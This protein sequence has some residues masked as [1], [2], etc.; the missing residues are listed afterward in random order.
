[1]NNANP[2]DHTPDGIPDDINGDGKITIGHVGDPAGSADIFIGDPVPL[3]PEELGPQDTVTV[4]PNEM[5][6]TVMHF[7]I[8]GLYVWHCHILSHEDNEMMRPFQVVDP[9]A[10]LLSA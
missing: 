8:A 6:S 10:G 7:D 5:L 4:D 1:M 2:A 9:H 3:R